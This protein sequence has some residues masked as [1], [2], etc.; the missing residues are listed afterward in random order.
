MRLLKRIWATRR[1]FMWVTPLAVISTGLLP[2]YGQNFEITPLVGATLGGTL[3]LEETGVPNY[4]AHI[5][6]AFSYGLAG[7]YRLDAG[8]GGH[9][10]FEFRWL[11]ESSHL[12]LAQ[13]PLIPTPY[14]ASSFRHSVTLDRFL[15]DFSHEFPIQE[16]STIEPFVSASMGAALMSLPASSATRFAFGLGAGVKIFPA[17]HWGFRLEAEYQPIVMHTELQRLV[18]SGGCIVVL[19]G[20]IMNQFQLS[21]GPAFRF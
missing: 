16:S 1:V 4:Y 8:D 5:A 21:I 17:P 12:F 6:D 2:V 7:G 18:C 15:G 20:G 9:D 13:S 3:H 19:N 11:R 14:G 10:V